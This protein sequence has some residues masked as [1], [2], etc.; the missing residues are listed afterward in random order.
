MEFVYSLQGQTSRQL[1][2]NLIDPHLRL[3]NTDKHFL[4]HFG[5]KVLDFDYHSTYQKSFKGKDTQEAP[6]RRRFRK[7]LPPADPG[8]VALTTTVTAW[9][10]EES[11]RHKTD[12][13]VLAV[14][15][16]PFLKHNPWKFSYNSKNNVYPPYDRRSEPIPD[17]TLNRYGPAFNNS[18]EFNLSGYSGLTSIKSAGCSV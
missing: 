18:N 16:E 12:T 8:P 17:N 3:H 14:S 10:P 1:G 13:Q 6:T 4:K 2:R 11:S 5:N 9:I 15:Q 7:S